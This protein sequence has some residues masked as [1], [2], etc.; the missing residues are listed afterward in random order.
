M[1]TFTA[2]ALKEMGSQQSLVE[3]SL[4]VCECMLGVSSLSGEKTTCVCVRVC[5]KGKWEQERPQL[6]VSSLSGSS[7]SSCLKTS[8]IHKGYPGHVCKRVFAFSVES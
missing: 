3:S 6:G 8:L 5:K 2:F 4:C 1:K 7:F